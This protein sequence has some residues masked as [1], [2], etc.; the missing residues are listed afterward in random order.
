MSE[1]QYIVGLKSDSFLL[2]YNSE[3]S[4]KGV[5]V[6]KSIATNSK[7]KLQYIKLPKDLA[8]GADLDQLINIGNG[9]LLA[10]MTKEKSNSNFAY[11]YSIDGFSSKSKPLATLKLPNGYNPT[12][13]YSSENWQTKGEQFF[14]FAVTSKDSASPI[15]AYLLGIDVNYNKS[16]K[17][18]TLA[19]EALPTSITATNLSIAT[20]LNEEK[21][22]TSGHGYRY[23]ADLVFQKSGLD[24]IDGYLLQPSY[25]N[26]V[27]YSLIP[28][29]LYTLGSGSNPVAADFSGSTS[30]NMAAVGTKNK[31]IDNN[32]D[33]RLNANSTLNYAMGDYPSIA[34]VYGSN[35]PSPYLFET[36]RGTDGSVWLNII[37]Y[38]ASTNK[39]TPNKSIQIA[40]N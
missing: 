12:I 16:S 22:P 27:G 20:F 35:S 4:F 29:E 9:K 38:N 30:I 5:I 19:K 25:Q 18:S 31:L 28:S 17:F 24:T 3:K 23:P 40:K 36:H 2:A 6:P 13:T 1:E 10:L 33:H 11:I 32:V 37:N 39:L 26:G 15:T 7:A 14:T 21:N 34:S 8:K